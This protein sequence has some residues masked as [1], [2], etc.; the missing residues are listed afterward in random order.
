[1]ALLLQRRKQ[2]LK[3]NEFHVCSVCRRYRHRSIQILLTVRLV[4]VNDFVF[5]DDAVEVIRDSDQPESFIAYE[6]WWKKNRVAAA[7]TPEFKYDRVTNEIN[8]D[9]MRRVSYLPN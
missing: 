3:E 1:M 5:W 8:A 7:K 4:Y 9:D 6:Q 2:R